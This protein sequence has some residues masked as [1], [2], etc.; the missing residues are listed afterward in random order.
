MIESGWTL[1]AGIVAVVVGALYSLL[2]GSLLAAA[3]V[4]VWLLARRWHRGA[5]GRSRGKQV[6]LAML[7]GLGALFIV[8]QAVPYGRSHTNPVVVK[9]PVWDSP[10]TR[11]LAVKSCF[12]CHSNETTWPWYS[13]IAPVSW[14]AYDHVVEGRHTLNFSEWNRSQEVDEVAETIHEGSMPPR[15]Y[16]LL[17]PGSGLSDAEKEQLVEGF[18]VTFQASP[19]GG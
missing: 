11:A 5:E 2:L 16:R 10:A 9:E 14:L 19:P 7:L 4:V 1:A 3:W 8:A 17:H 13:D 6:V 12:D 18:R 15:Y